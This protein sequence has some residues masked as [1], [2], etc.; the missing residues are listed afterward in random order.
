MTAVKHLQSTSKLMNATVSCSSGKNTL[1]SSC[2]TNPKLTHHAAKVECLQGAILVAGNELIECTCR[3]NAKV[4]LNA[5][6]T[7]E[8]TET[9]SFM[10]PV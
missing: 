3:A 7:A 9:T 2:R 10:D 8:P 4:R 5:A 6:L 1:K